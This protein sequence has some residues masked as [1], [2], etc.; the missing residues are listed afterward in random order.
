ML[1]SPCRI[2]STTSAYQ[3]GPGSGCC[4]TSYEQQELR[5][6]LLARLVLPHKGE[7]L[8]ISED[9]RGLLTLAG[10]KDQWPEKGR[11]R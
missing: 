8:I 1:L 6:P 7:A 2:S 11:E 3:D 9:W 4:L 10:G 5:V